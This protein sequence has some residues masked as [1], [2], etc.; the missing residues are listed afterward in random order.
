MNLALK[1]LLP[2]SCF[3]FTTAASAAAEVIQAPAGQ[4]TGKVVQDT[5]QYQGIPYA[6]PP[7]GQLRWKAPQPVSYL[8]HYQATS[9]KSMCTQPGSLF[10]GAENIRG[11]ADC[12]YLN[13]YVPEQAKPKKDLPVM[14]WIHGG[15][16]LTGSGDQ[17][18]PTLLT[19]NQEVITVSLNYRLGA[20]GFL[21]RADLDDASGNFGTL[22]QQLAMK[23]VKD[24][25][26]AF[27]GDANNI[28][29][30]GESAGGMSV[31]A[32]L[33]MPKQL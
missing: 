11:S 8:N 10:G 21:S 16:F 15:G 17:F 14:V 18:D 4:F 13:V 5:I 20:L 24:N 31:G 1:V 29:I 30:F 27:G 2:L 7:V 33:L 26:S 6:K 25:I 12:L 3:A 9:F 22:D 23:W 28:T 19:Q 32:H